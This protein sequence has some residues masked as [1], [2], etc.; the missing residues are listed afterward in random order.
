MA[1]I[2]PDVLRSVTERVIDEF[3]GAAMMFTALDVSNVVKLTLADARH[4]DI[5]PIV[6]AMF[7]RDGMGAYQ[8]TMIDVMAGGAKPARAYLYHLP[9]HPASMYDDSMR[10]QLAIPPVSPSKTDDDTSVTATS[11]EAR[12]KI[13]KDGR[14]RVSRRLLANAGMTGDKVRV[15][16][17]PAGARLVI[18]D[19]TPAAG[20]DTQVLTFEHPSLLHV[21]RTI[22][23]T[24]GSHASLMAKIDGASV[25][26]VPG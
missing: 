24:F 9:E 22:M 4:R 11:T 16:T 20:T 14:G 21:P 5:A 17:D 3:T 26:V 12:V 8:Q 1:D 13:G 23:D 2:S 15:R 25:V 10:S 18:V 7:D 19:D 6:R